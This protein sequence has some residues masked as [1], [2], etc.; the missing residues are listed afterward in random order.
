MRNLYCAA[1][2]VIGVGNFFIA[3][4]AHAEESSENAV[5][6]TATRTAQTVDETLASVTVITRADIQRSQATSVSEILTGLAGIDSAVNGGYGK[7]TSLFMRGTNSDHILVMVDGVKIGSA[8][9]GTTAFEFL[10][11]SQIERIEV[12]RG[13]R[14]SLYGSEA[15]GGVIQ[16][17][18]RRGQD[19]SGASFEAGAG[20]YNTRSVSAGMSSIQN[21]TGLSMTAARFKT[22]GFNACKGSLTDACFTIEPDK[23]GYTNDSVSARLDHRFGNNATLDLHALR[24][25]GRT[26]YDGTLQNTAKFIQQAVGVDAG[27]SPLDNWRAKLS[28]GQSQDNTDN[29]KD[30]TF[31]SQ[32]DT[33][34]NVAAWQNDISWGKNSLFTLGVDRQEDRVTSNP[35]TYARDRRRNKSVF[36]QFQNRLEK[37]DFLVSARRDD[38]DAFGKYSTGNAA[39]GYALSPSRR[40][41]ASYGTGFKAP[42]LN[43]LYYTD[44]YG[45]HGN[46]NLLPEKSKSIETGLQGKQ[47]WGDWDVRV[48]QTSIDNL[49]VWVTDSTTFISTTQNID[50]ARIRG[51]EIR[52]SATW[53]DWKSQANVTITDPRD[54]GSNHILAHRSQQMLKLDTD[55]AFGKMHF[56]ASWFAQSQR[57]EYDYLGN[58]SAKMGAYGLLNLRAQ[59]DLS[60]DWLLRAHFDN[61]L[62]KQ[63]ETVHNYNIQGRSIFVSLNY[64]AR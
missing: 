46:P 6:V 14:S 23:D 62:D 39:W 11:L 45:N 50:K 1:V 26:D 5:V 2:A 18:T 24:A 35:T 4:S 33:Q 52:A 28:S 61:A 20:S 36:S 42:T 16:I 29:F 38:N 43:D 34:R 56:G 49:I 17:F 37:N 60:K 25:Q 12:V 8:T 40:L 48:Y 31:S 30:R 3:L 47:N 57:Y 53:L 15:I 58:T 22:A 54:I 59:Y 41:T 64:Q 51:L 32:F 7:T 27:F 13:P 63:Y 19:K 10:P 44:V 21:D 9:L 55:R